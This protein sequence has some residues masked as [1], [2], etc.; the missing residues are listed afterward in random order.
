MEEDLELPPDLDTSG[1]LGAAEEGAGY[2]VAPT[3][4]QP[5]TFYWTTNSRLAA[6]HV[7]AGSFDTAARLLH[8]QL[9]VV[10]LEP[11]RQQFLST[12]SR[13]V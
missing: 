4:G 10:K 1:K 13:F 9:G 8:D 5:P 7:L 2:F 11:F 3:R 6:D 12:F